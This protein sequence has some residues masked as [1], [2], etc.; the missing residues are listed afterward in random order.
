MGVKGACGRRQKTVAQRDLDGSRARPKHHE[1]PTPKAGP[2]PKPAFLSELE[3]EH[4]DVLLALL[5]HRGQ[6]T[7][8]TGQWLFT[9][10]SAYSDLLKWRETAARV[11]M[12]YEH[13]VD[14][15]GSTEP[16]THPAHVQHRIARAHY[17]AL[18]KEAGLTPASISRVVV[19]KRPDVPVDP[20][21]A[22]QQRGSSGI[23][24]VK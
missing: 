7:Q 14:L 9:A 16:K 12:T 19:P 4:W 24:L 6:L 18:L 10:V 5:E 3:R 21:A 13:V 20:F 11:P 17:V 8:D 2:P 23:R 1:Q 15:L 22:F